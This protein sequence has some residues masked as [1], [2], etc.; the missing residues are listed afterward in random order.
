[1]DDILTTLAR[2]CVTW[3]EQR[4]APGLRARLLKALTLLETR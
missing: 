1:V 3:I 2:A 4:D